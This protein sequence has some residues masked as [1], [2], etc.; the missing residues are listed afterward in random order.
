MTVDDPLTAAIIDAVIKV[1]KEL[2][3]GFGEAIYRRA[4]LIELRKREMTVGTEVEV[5]VTY[6]GEII[7]RYRI[8]L[9]VERRVI[10]ELKAI[11]K[12]AAVHYA[13][14][15]SY[16]HATRLPLGSCAHKRSMSGFGVRPDT[17]LADL[18]FRF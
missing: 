10:V 9:L 13:Q 3:P 15:R 5:D 18:D 1:H 16:L 8:D 17:P 2:G 4:L 11:E 12:L 14:V 6:V 7:G